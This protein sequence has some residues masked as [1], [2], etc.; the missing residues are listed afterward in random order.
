VTSE[1]ERVAARFR[2]ELEARELEATRTMRRQLADTE[3]RI[4]R[5]LER[6]LATIERATDAGR[7][8]G[9]TALYERGRL[10]DLHRQVAAA[11]R[12]YGAQ[13]APVVERL[14]GDSADKAV[15]FSGEFLEAAGANLGQASS[16]GA[17]LPALRP[18]LIRQARAN[19]AP[20][21]PLRDLFDSF[22]EDA[23][24]RVA[25][26]ITSGIALGH[27]PD[28]IARAI[29]SDVVETYAHRSRLI[30]RTE[31]QRVV[32]ATTR[33]AYRASGVAAGWRWLSSLD[34]TTC[35]ACWGQHGSL[36]DL[37]EVLEGHPGCRC[38]MVPVLRS[39]L[40][41]LTPPQVGDGEALFAEAASDVQA[42]VL[43]P[44]KLEAYRAGEI[45]L[46]DLTERQ[47]S[48]R[49][50]AMY[51]EASLK[52]ALRRNGTPAPPPRGLPAPEPPTPAPQP[53][54]PAP[55]ELVPGLDQARGFVP[56]LR[57]R[58]DALDELAGKADTLVRPELRAAA[59]KLR[60]SWKAGETGAGAM[61]R[62]GIGNSQEWGSGD[63]FY[64]FN[65]GNE[66][67]WH[68]RPDGSGKRLTLPGY[69]DLIVAWSRGERMPE[70]FRVPDDLEP[71]SED[72]LETLDL[73]RR[74]RDRAAAD[75]RV[76]DI[77]TADPDDWR[78]D[79]ADVR[80]AV[81]EI[82]RTVV[83]GQRVLRAAQ[84]RLE[85]KPPA[86]PAPRP[87][88]EPEPA[89]PPPP[90]PAAPE[91]PAV[92]LRD[93]LDALDLSPLEPDLTNPI[94][95]AMSRTRRFPEIAADVRLA[96]RLIGRLI[97]VP[98]VGRRIPVSI[99]P[100][101]HLRRTAGQ[102]AIRNP[103]GVP[104]FMKLNNLHAYDH[105]RPG[106]VVHEFGHYLDAVSSPAGMATE[107]ARELGLTEWAEAVLQS[108][109]VR[110]IAGDRGWS[111]KH[112]AYLLDP[113]EL[114]ARSF[115][116]WVALRSGPDG[117][118]IR[119]GLE[120]RVDHWDDDDF[121]PIA[122]AIDRYVRRRGWTP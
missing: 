103:D 104:E 48:P 77:L 47:E 74:I 21:S 80:V 1:L 49:W 64:R 75:R 115:T 112:K 24:E 37:D 38:T 27:N 8:P 85:P 32:R 99:D 63:Q 79:V 62:R 68:Y 12:E 66:N 72:A 111:D 6:H 14:L 18:E 92:P 82:Q 122:E 114:W 98:D 97:R 11:M 89:P 60:D 40:A 29:R 3:Q 90:A 51:R 58:A 39:E 16:A 23:G 31:S 121:E 71:L 101:L 41:Q 105:L 76:T 67:S 116:Q 30:A 107:F 22:G 83:E 70:G 102:I 108:R 52:S 100:N 5:Q 45:T 69:E 110:N 13:A 33:E 87:A 53:T 84:E 55:T 46:R 43:G 28:V 36:H 17:I 65:A 109:A 117:D 7:E 59:R 50:G 61:R 106:T 96:M 25:N 94:M 34:R 2:R 73:A 86:P 44:A 119:R 57:A 15:T 78:F 20:G 113:R 35:A 56:P 54:P 9:I 4:G 81:A 95:E 10:A 120:D 26:G 19:M 93:P 91:P 118:V 42:A 88:P